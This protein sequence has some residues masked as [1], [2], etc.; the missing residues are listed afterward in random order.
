MELIIG[1][2]FIT[3]VIAGIILY[4]SFSWGFVASKFY[5]WFV[6]SIFPTAPHFTVTQFIGIAFFIMAI[7]P[8]NSIDNLKEEYKSKENMWFTLFFSPWISLIMGYFISLFF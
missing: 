4:N 6:L 5:L 8:K 2:L 3:A 7:M 1:F